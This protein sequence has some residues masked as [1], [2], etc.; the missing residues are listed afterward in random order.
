MNICIRCWD[1]GWG[2]ATA[3][4]LNKDYLAII[5]IGSKSPRSYSKAKKKIH[6]LIR[7]RFLCKDLFITHPHY[8]HFSLIDGL[9]RKKPVFNALFLPALPM[10]PK[11]IRE[12]CFMAMA[13]LS[14]TRLSY[15]ELFKRLSNVAYNI[16]LLTRG[17]IIELSPCSCFAIVLWPP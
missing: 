2:D 8:D 10:H 17:N 4:S 1:V 13:F 7:K 15:Y 6:R 11:D 3:F 14:Y 9:A 5:D 16:F 12:A